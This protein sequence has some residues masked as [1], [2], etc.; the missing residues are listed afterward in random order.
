MCSIVASSSPLYRT[1]CG[2]EVT[3]AIEANA[4]PSPNH[5]N[6]LRPFKGWAIFVAY[7]VLDGA[8]LRSSDAFHRLFE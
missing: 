8:A 5:I 4:S 6:D 2:G 7:I 1:L 3:E